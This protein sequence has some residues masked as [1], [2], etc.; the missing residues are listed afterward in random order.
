MKHTLHLLGLQLLVLMEQYVYGILS[1]IGKTE[2]GSIPRDVLEDVVAGTDLYNQAVEEY[3]IQLNASQFRMLVLHVT[4]ESKFFASIPKITRFNSSAVSVKS[5]ISVLA[6]HRA[7]VVARQLDLWISEEISHVCKLGSYHKACSDNFI[8]HT[9]GCSCSWER[10][11]YTYLTSSPLLF[12]K[13]F[14]TYTPSHHLH[15]CALENHLPVLVKLFTFQYKEERSIKNECSQCQTCK[16]QSGATQLSA[17]EAQSNLER[18]WDCLS[19]P[20]ATSHHASAVLPHQLDQS[21]V[22]PLF[23]VLVTSTDLLSPLALQRPTAKETSDQL[24]PVSVQD[25]AGW[26][27]GSNGLNTAAHSNTFSKQSGKVT[28]NP[29]VQGTEQDWTELKITA[30]DATER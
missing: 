19:P 7:E 16:T 9:S 27:P 3:N 14:P 18:N 23:Q 8:S 28:N 21:S 20:V 15:I 11:W 6:V 2:A 24:A 25:A 30:G 13:S 4:H 26:N 10:L 1:V 12:D 5:L 22:E 29:N 17:E